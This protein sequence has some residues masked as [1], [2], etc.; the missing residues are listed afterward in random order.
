MARTNRERGPRGL[1]AVAIVG[2]VAGGVLVASVPLAATGAAVDAGAAT[3]GQSASAGPDQVSPQQ[4][5]VIVSIE[6]GTVE[7]DG[8]ATVE[9][10]VANASPEAIRGV[11]VRL[12]SRFADVSNPERV[13]SSLEPGEGR[14]FTYDLEDASPGPEEFDVFVRYTDTEGN[15]KGEHR[16]RY[17]EFSGTQGPHPDV[18]IDA[19]EI[20]PGGVT[21]LNLTVANGLDQPIRALTVEID[22]EGFEVAEPRR[23]HSGLESG[24]AAAFSFRANDASP[25]PTTV[26]VD[27]TYTTA[28]GSERQ[29]R[30]E[31][32][33]TLEAVSNPPRVTL[34]ELRVT[35]E[36]ERLTVRGSAS[37]VGGSAATSVVVAVED[38]DGVGPA[39]SESTFFV[40]EV[41]ESDFSSFEVSAALDAT[42]SVEIP[43]RV[44]YDAGDAR[45]NRTVG[46][47]YVAAS[48]TP[49]EDEPDGGGEGGGFPAALVA[50][51]LVA[52]TAVVVV[53]RQF[54]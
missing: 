42:G 39:Q 22:P 51:V 14:T 7:Q 29:I 32:G 28:N 24:G 26:P 6:T 47:D 52:L 37:N 27:L 35:R 18:G 38:G 50:A 41:P 15:R 36:G 49:A 13:A 53:W 25:G 10:T 33:L 9:V 31:L 30:R 40:G 44:S 12:E 48:T 46:V 21:N 3:A 19:G 20:S 5:R 2:L 17:V 45:V 16:K 11:A 4:Q 23:V 34:T 54:R 43:V 1:L 8:D